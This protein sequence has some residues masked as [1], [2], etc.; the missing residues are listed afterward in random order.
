MRTIT[1]MFDSRAEAHD[2]CDRLMES[3]VRADRIRII[4]RNAAGGPL[5]TGLV[6]QHESFWASLVDMFM[7]EEQRHLYGEHIRRGGFL[8]R[9]DV[10]DAQVDRAT[11]LLDEAGSIDFELRQREWLAEGW[12]GFMADR[13]AGAFGRLSGGDTYASGR[14]PDE[15]DGLA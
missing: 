7:P 3:D 4:D 2:A 1:A 15:R 13:Q 14:E 9:A 12:T 5:G 11:R 6:E 10:D 8:L